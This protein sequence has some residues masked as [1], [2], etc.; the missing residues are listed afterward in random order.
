MSPE[1][2]LELEET[3]ALKKRMW[4]ELRQIKGWHSGSEIQAGQEAASRSLKQQTHPVILPDFA[5]LRQARPD[6]RV[7]GVEEARTREFPGLL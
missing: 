3:A 7:K 2:M 5:M 6:V 1:P 4:T